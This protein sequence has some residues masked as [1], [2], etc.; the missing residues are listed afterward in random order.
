MIVLEW[1][2]VGASDPD[3]E[4]FRF[5]EDEDVEDMKTDHKTITEGFID[6]GASEDEINN[7]FEV[8]L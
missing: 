4:F 8:L 7:C 2:L 1:V 5:F 3:S 6:M